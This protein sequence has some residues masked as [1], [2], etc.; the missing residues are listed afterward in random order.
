MTDILK[1]SEK[2]IYNDLNLQK[3]LIKEV[4]EKYKIK[5][6]IGCRSCIN[7]AL[8]LLKRT[9]KKNTNME[10]RYKLKDGIILYVGSENNDYTN[11]NITD[12]KARELIKKLGKKVLGNFSKYPADE[13]E[14]LLKVE[15]KKEKKEETKIENSKMLEDILNKYSKQDLINFLNDKKVQFKASLKKE[16]L[17]KMLIQN[18]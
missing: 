13:V 11:H 2:E 7:D 3:A 12:E 9:V 16:E 14:N 5:F 6:N 10:K 8:I 18:I 1:Y 17:A 4:E 15:V